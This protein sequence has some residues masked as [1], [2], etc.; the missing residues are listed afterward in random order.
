MDHHAAITVEEVLS[1]VADVRLLAGTEGVKRLVR[2][3]GVM[4]TPDV[5]P[6]IKPGELIL[7]AMFAVKDDHEAQV[8]LIPELHRRGAAGLALKKRYI[9]ELP[10]AMVEQANR[11][12][13]PLL[14]LKVE[15]A[16]SDVMLPVF[17]QIVNRQASV[18]AHQQNAHKA[19]MKAVLEGR[20]LPK[21]ATTL[22]ELVCNPVVIRDSAGEI[23][24]TAGGEG[25]PGLD[26]EA[27]SRLEPAS[28]EYMV[29]GGDT[30]HRSEQVV[31]AGR[32]I[33][34]TVTPIVS[35]DHTYGQILVWETGRPVRELDLLVIDS[36]ST[37]VALELANQ[38][39]VLE[40]ERRYKGEFLEA[41]FAREIESEVALVQRARTF[42]W[43][44]NRPHFA[45]ALRLA[46]VES[47]P[48]RPPEEVQRAKDQYF[49]I[50]SKAAGHGMVG[51]AGLHIVVLIQPNPRAQDAKEHALLQAQGLL[52]LA[53]PLKKTLRV[54]AGIG[55]AYSG[56]QGLRKSFEEAS[57]AVSVGEKVWGGSAAY[58]YDD[59]G[60]YQILSMLE[61][62]ADM[63]QFLSAIDKLVEYE[64]DSRTDLVQTL[65]TY[66]AC[67][68]NVRKV[69]EKLFAHYNTVLYR[70]ERI[71][72][73]TGVQLE[74]ATGRLHLQVALQAARLFGKL[75]SAAGHPS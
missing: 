34:R 35:G 51:Q 42:G 66:F 54:T 38:R 17:S 73:I 63:Q 64:R 56:V 46:G 33:S 45:V 72:Q 74:D 11:L 6:M 7:S 9:G 29:S 47:R 15:T 3:V 19:V 48:A 4:E 52:G 37:V 23:L 40:V 21:L 10:P 53:E 68:G 1:L 22:A 26:L 75:P 12:A 67:K 49:E 55:R 41:L 57:R 36:V 20:G 18:L 5:F 24:A 13:F 61:P 31:V 2:S 50:I 28:G 16:F 14:E 25:A 58:H 65:E 62:N 71:Q 70:L 39:A 59:L 43:D 44:L 27:I 32:R 8:A 69:S 30:L 60:L